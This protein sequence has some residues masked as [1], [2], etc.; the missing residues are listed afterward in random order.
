MHTS[1]IG[2]LLTKSNINIFDEYIKEFEAYFSRTVTSVSEMRLRDNKKVK[3][4]AWELFCRD[5]LLSTD[6]YNNVWLLAEYF[7]QHNLT[8]SKQD[9]GIDLVAYTKDQK[10]VAVQCKYRK[11]GA[12]VDWKS[13]ATFIGLCERTPGFSTYL[14]MTNC[15]GVTRKVPRTSKD[16]SICVGTFRKTPRVQWLK[17]TAN[18][19]EHRLIDENINHP[20][21]VALRQLRLAKFS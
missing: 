3:G 9:N 21:I 5:W 10:W 13:L 20:D 1:I 7:Q 8:G 4:D 14:V 15:K 19:V 17:M 6:K 18:Y 2:K 11:L 12:Y 16:K